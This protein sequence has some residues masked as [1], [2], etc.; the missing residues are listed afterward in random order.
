MSTSKSLGVTLLCFGRLKGSQC[1]SEGWPNSSDDLRYCPKRDFTWEQE[2]KAQF[3]A[4]AACHLRFFT[5]K[6]G[7][8]GLKSLQEDE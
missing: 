6:D 4:L 5:G 7:V 2:S 8:Q 3:P 1:I